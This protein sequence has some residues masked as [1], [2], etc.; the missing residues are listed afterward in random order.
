MELF[1]C[2]LSRATPTAE[3]SCSPSDGLAKVAGKRDSLS[4]SLHVTGLLPLGNGLVFRIG[5]ETFDVAA[6]SGA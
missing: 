3:A 1:R 5:S 2:H 6:P 4:R